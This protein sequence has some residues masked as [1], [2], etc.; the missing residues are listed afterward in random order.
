[1]AEGGGKVNHKREVYPLYPCNYKKEQIVI[2]A[3]WRCVGNKGV[4]DEK[5]LYG[6]MKDRFRVRCR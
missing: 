3:V 5:M 2:G 6:F 1:M 4:M